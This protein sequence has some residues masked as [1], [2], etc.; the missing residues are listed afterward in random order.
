MNKVKKPNMTKKF[1]VF[2]IGNNHLTP[3][4]LAPLYDTEDVAWDKLNDFQIQGEFVIL[5]VFIKN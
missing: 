4:P 5:P 2:R 1:R 3:L